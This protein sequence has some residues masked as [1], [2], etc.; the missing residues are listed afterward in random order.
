[1]TATAL[2]RL[3]AESQELL[4]EAT[5]AENQK[6]L[7]NRH[8]N[9]QQALESCNSA[10]ED[11]YLE[12]SEHLREI[13]A[14]IEQ[15]ESRAAL[16][17]AAAESHDGD[18]FI[19]QRLTQ[20]VE[21]MTSAHRESVQKIVDNRERLGTFNITLF[22]RTMTGKSTLKEI[23]TEGDG[24]SIGKG[25]QRTTRDVREYEWHGMNII[26]VPG[27]AAFGGGDDENTAF[28][29]ARKA[30]L[31]L[32]LITDDAPQEAEVEHLAGL[33]TLG[34]PVLGICNVK[35]ALNNR[36]RTQIRR[37]LRDQERIF[38]PRK[39][40]ELTKQFHRLAERHG[41]GQPVR[42]Q[43]AH[44][45]SRFLAY[46][47]GYE[48]HREELEEASRFGDIED[49]ICDEISRN[50]PF[51]RQRSFL[52]SASRASF[53]ALQQ[54]LEAA[55][56]ARSLH[57]RIWDHARETR[58][59]REQFRQHVDIRIETLINE[60]IGQLRIA[61][62][63][64]A[65]QNCEK[66]DI[67]ELWKRRVEE[68]GINRKANELQRTLSQEAERKLKTLSEELDQELETFNGRMETPDISGKK[69][70]NHRKIWDWGTMGIS[71]ALG[72][73]AAAGFVIP[74]LAPLSLVLVISGAVV[75]LVG[76]ILRGWF[77]DRDKR[78]QESIGQIIPELH[79][80]LN[81][82][83]A[84]TRNDLQEWIKDSLLGGPVDRVIRQ[85]ENADSD[86]LWAARYYREQADALNQRQMNL[87]LRLVQKALESIPGAPTLQEDTAVARLP[88][89][90]IAVR[91]RGTLR[92]TDLAELES[93]LQERVETVPVTASSKEIISWATGGRTHPDAITTD[94]QAGAAYVPYDENSGETRDRMNIAMQLTGLYIKN[95]T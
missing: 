30:D 8:I 74:P 84:S 15:A 54:M 61:I 48:E 3:L 20:A 51:H 85:L 69:I 83:E 66:E 45:R 70:H 53:N 29:A 7:R 88:G 93:L 77:G 23:L 14:I 35:A 89:Q 31:I 80:N 12:A 72:L 94:D 71:S 76:R 78:R 5:R 10:A 63:A 25:Q 42:F 39:L 75:G 27:M 33:R 49:L 62:P 86:T 79:R 68:T 18:G 81:V 58:T 34:V 65:E 6:R 16:L 87:N 92:K 50:G 9:L 17:G 22:G 11:G 91:N 41:A 24:S 32:F 46:R 43:H 57:E 4:N 2:L 73:A 21:D 28:E 95:T 56:T 37:F 60:T 90:L 67:A 36:N 38:D 64:F 40:D 26:D 59:W 52:E 19:L 13:G 1:M 44:L 47:P 82:L 55:D